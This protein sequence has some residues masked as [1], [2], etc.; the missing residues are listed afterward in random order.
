MVGQLGVAGANPRSQDRRVSAHPLLS[1]RLSH[2][3]LARN[4]PMTMT[5]EEIKTYLRQRFPLIMVD[6]VLEVEPGKRI[7]ALKNVT[8]NEI[9]FLGHFPDYA[10]M[11]GTFIVEAI[12][13]CASVLFSQTTGTGVEKGEFLVLA[14][15][16]DMR[17][18]V[19]VH[20]GHTMI[21]EVTISKM[22]AG[23]ALVEGV[24]TV[25][26]TVVTRG[27]LSFARKVV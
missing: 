16:N 6:R 10:I 14:A 17:F 7:K 2:F 3:W 27:R 19:P 23:A 5:F 22:T 8:G 1:I 9:Q 21:L 12:G 13:Q 20:P 25:D 4:N 24:V 26:G 11:P 18:L 15:I